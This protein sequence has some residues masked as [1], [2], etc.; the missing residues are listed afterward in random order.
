MNTRQLT[1]NKVSSKRQRFHSLR[2]QLTITLLGACLVMA[3][4]N[5]HNDDNDSAPGAPQTM[6]GYNITVTNLTAAQPLSPAAVA[7]HSNSWQSFVTGQPAST[8]LEQ[9]AE[10]G[11][12][13]AW[14]AT[15]SA[16]TEVYGSVG[17]TG[18]IPPGGS[19]TLNVKVDEDKVGTLYVTVVSMLVNTNDALAAVNKQNIA[20]MAVGDKVSFNALSYDSGTEANSETADTIPGPAATGGAQ[21]GFNAV[22]DDVRDAVYV[23]AGVI[24]ADDGLISSALTAVH[25]WD[26]PAIRVTVERTE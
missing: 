16:S 13:S 2:Q 4:C 25:R 6:A 15:A 10:G 26:H 24:T 23:H 22:R 19:E 3:G 11:D 20:S 21:E 5:N 18:A 12:N 9:L 17:G 14:L 7:L 8:D 1:P